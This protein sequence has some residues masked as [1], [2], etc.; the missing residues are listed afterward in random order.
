M[1]QTQA[2]TGTD[3]TFLIRGEDD[4]YAI[5]VALLEQHRIPDDRRTQL[6]AA[7]RQQLPDGGEPVEAPLYELPTAALTP[8]RL[9]D[10]ERAAL[11]EQFARQQADG[12]AHGFK[13][14]PNQPK[15]EA[16]SG[17]TGYAYSVTFGRMERGA[18]GQQTYIGVFPMFQATLPDPGYYPQ[19]R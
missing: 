8:Y 14:A 16:I 18:S 7:L 2:P 3:A 6:A 9:P 19:L 15:G 12:D 1:E 4:A 17:Y 13:Y 10:A 5:P 11:E